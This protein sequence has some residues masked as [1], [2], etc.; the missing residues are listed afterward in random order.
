VRLTPLDV[1]RIRK[2]RYR[3]GLTSPQVA[4]IIGCDESTVRYYAPGRI[5]KVPIDKL[6]AAFEA[7]GLTAAEVARRMGWFD[8][9]CADS[10]RVKRALG[11]YPSISNG[12]RSPRRMIDAET[13]GLLAEAIGVMAWE[14]MPD[15]EQEAA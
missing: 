1:K 9:R 6:R 11:I 7:S 12:R 5:G 3:D 15:D 13:A 2:L 10:A 14:V 4:K 8:G